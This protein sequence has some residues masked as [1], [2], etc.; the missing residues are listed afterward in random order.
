MSQKYYFYLGGSGNED[1]IYILLCGQKTNRQED[2]HHKSHKM[3]M[4][5]TT[6]SAIA[7]LFPLSQM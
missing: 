2:K 6:S 1:G 4:V 3:K 5:I 7:P